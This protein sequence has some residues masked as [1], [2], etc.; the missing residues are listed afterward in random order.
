MNSTN[1]LNVMWTWLLFTN[2]RSFLK[3]QNIPL[4]KIICNCS[5]YKGKLY[6]GMFKE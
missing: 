3:V 6:K 1:T 5:L 2:D 4:L